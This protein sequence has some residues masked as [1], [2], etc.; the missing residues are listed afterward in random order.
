MLATLYRRQL[1]VPDNDPTR[2]ERQAR[3]YARKRA[4]GLVP[5]R[6]WLP[7]E[8]DRDEMHEECRRRREAAQH[9]EEHSNE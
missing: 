5:F 6:D 2:R 3:H 1:T 7:S 9:Q 8:K 4:A